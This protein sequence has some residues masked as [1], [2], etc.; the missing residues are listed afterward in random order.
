MQ[1]RALVLIFGIILGASELHAQPTPAPP[2]GMTQEQFDMLVD[3]ISKSVVEKMKAEGGPGATPDPKKAKSEK[4]ATPT[5][6]QVGRTP[7][8]QGPSQFAL[9]LQRAGK[10]VASYPVLGQQLA[11]LGRGLD[12]RANGGWEVGAF[13][14]VV[15]LIGA[16]AVTFLGAPAH[17]R[18][19]GDLPSRQLP[20][21][22]PPRVEYRLT[23][24][25][26]SMLPI[27]E[28]MRTFGHEWLIQDHD[29]DHTDVG[30]V[31]AL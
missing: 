9:L 12:Q 29:H 2:A 30:R 16:V 6:V 17:A 22:S 28:E 20:R 31:A 13:A 3:A 11:A 26:R 14:I 25:G 8:K 10:V 23:D 21:E 5:Q 7:P 1:L 18:G 19:A 27:I 24:K 15:A 4:G